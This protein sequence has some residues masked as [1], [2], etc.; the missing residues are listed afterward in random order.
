MKNLKDFLTEEKKRQPKTSSV[1][2][3]LGEDLSRIVQ[4]DSF[5]GTGKSDTPAAAADKSPVADDMH[6]D[7]ASSVEMGDEMLKEIDRKRV[8]RPHTSAGKM[9]ASCGILYPDS[10][11]RTVWDVIGFLMIFY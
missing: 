9:E 4:M 10:T 2:S 6:S 3:Q 11:L 7:S 8:F 5:K 1:A